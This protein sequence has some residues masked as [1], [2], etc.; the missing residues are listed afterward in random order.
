MPCWGFGSTRNALRSLDEISL[1]NLVK[2]YPIE[3]KSYQDARIRE[4][5][6]TNPDQR[7]VGS[8]LKRIRFA[9]YGE[10]VSEHC[11]EFGPDYWL[12]RRGSELDSCASDL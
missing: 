8:F 2:S 7:S 5:L 4:W 6:N 1:Q 11:T 3:G 10:R 12:P 9:L